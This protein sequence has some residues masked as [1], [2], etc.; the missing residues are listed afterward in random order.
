MESTTYFNIDVVSV[1][2][3]SPKEYFI[4]SSTQSD[5]E[6]IDILTTLSTFLRGKQAGAITCRVAIPR[7]T[8]NKTAQTIKKYVPELTCP[9]TWFTQNPVENYPIFTIQLHALS[10]CPIQMIQNGSS[11]AGCFFEDDHVKYYQLRL[12]P[13]DRQADNQ[14][15]TYSVFQKMD[16]VLKPFGLDF[17]STARTWLYAHDILS[18]YDKLNLARDRFFNEK[19]V[20][21]NRIPASTGVSLSNPLDYAIETELLAA[22]P[23]NGS[24]QI[25]PVASPLQCPATQ[26]RSSFS[27]AM[28]IATPEQKRLYISGTASIDPYGKTIFVGNTPQQIDHTMKV[29]EAILKNVGMEWINTVRAIAYFKYRNDY[30]LLDQWLQKHNITLPHIKLECDI[31]RDDLLFELELDAIQIR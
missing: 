10:G 28:E 3:K 2:N 7:D 18:W 4:S 24:A 26:Y 1:E 11:P 16:A 23:K 13:D 9:I 5:S 19:D 29:V 6:Q 8:R 21:N 25:R 31:C 15:Q 14:A 12:F 20:F 17:H 27:R 22:V 30:P